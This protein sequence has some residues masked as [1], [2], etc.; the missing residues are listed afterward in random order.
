[1]LDDSFKEIEANSNF[2]ELNLFFN[3]VNI[4][5]SQV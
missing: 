4:S 3:A 1:M 5:V 2:F